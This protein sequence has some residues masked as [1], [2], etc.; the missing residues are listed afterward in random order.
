MIY[1]GPIPQLG[2]GTFGRTGD[3]GVEAMLKTIEI[4]Y[5]QVNIADGGMGMN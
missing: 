2:L 3:A 4:G 1:S 5:R